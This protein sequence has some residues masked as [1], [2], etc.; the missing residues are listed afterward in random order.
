MFP[1]YTSTRVVELGFRMRAP[2]LGLARN[3]ISPSVMRPRS[4]PLPLSLLTDT[5]CIKSRQIASQIRKRTR[6]ILTMVSATTIKEFE[7]VWPRIVADLVAHS[8]QYKLPQQ[9]LDWFIK[10]NIFARL[11]TH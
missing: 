5:S 8:K 3:I 10:V 1:L 9:S 6:K 4:F 7:S 2:H 11:L